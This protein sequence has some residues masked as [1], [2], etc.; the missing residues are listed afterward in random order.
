M[1]LGCFLKR[2]SG[3]VILSPAALRELTDKRRSDA[4]ARELQHLGIPFRTRRD[5]SIIV[6]EE[7]VNGSAAQKRPASPALRLP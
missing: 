2:Q 5:G 7:H 4:Q 6:L 3:N 1:S